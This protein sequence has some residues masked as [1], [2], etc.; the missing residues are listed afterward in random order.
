MIPN[1]PRSN[2][3]PK[4]KPGPHVNGI[5]GCT[6]TKPMDSVVKQVIQLSLNQSVTGNATNLSQPTQ[7]ENVL[8]V[9]N[10]NPKGIQQPRRNKKKGKN[11]HKGGNKNKISNDN[12]KNTNAGGDK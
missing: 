9:Q 5:L 10:L 6:S 4:V 1:A 3:D 2:F 11:N 12:D 7:S 8:S